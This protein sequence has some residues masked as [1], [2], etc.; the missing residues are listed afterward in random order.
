MRLVRAGRRHCTVELGTLTVTALLDR[1]T[2]AAH[3]PLRDADGGP[4]TGSAAR[5][6]ARAF[7]V[8]GPGGCLMIDSGGGGTL[9]AAMTEAGISPNA[10]SVLALT[11]THAGHIGG[12]LDGQGG[13]AFPNATRLFV[14]VEE[15]GIFR[16]TAGMWPLLPLLMPLEQGDGVFP[17][18]SAINAPGHSPGHMAYLADG[19]LLIW[20]DLVHD[21][22][23]QFAAPDIG[24]HSDADP[25]G[26]RASRKALMEQAVEAGWLVA[27]AH[28]PAPGIGWIER[29]GAGYAFRPLRG[30]S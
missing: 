5:F 19:R 8:Q 29:D 2:E 15:L 22:G 14:A 28:L 30:I 26:A 23:V 3:E 27:G 20:G 21:A 25:V 4:V 9:G 6:P 7:A 13:R 11:H 24:W 18:V 1:E 12:F 10:V 16:Q 17:G